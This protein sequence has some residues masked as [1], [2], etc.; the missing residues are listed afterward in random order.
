MYLYNVIENNVNP[1]KEHE[2]KN[3]V[4]TVALDRVCVLVWRMHEEGSLIVHRLYSENAIYINILKTKK[5]EKIA[6]KGPLLEAILAIF[7]GGSLTFFVWKLLE[8][9]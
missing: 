7:G 3:P 6:Q 1:A 4:P 2:E 5:K 8:I 9:P